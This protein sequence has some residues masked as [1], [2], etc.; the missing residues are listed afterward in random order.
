MFKKCLK[1]NPTFISSQHHLGIMYHRTKQF[2]NALQCY[3]QVL[4]KV[5]TDK[6]G[7]IVYLARGQVY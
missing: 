1:H 5:K 2:Q 7:K 3:S 4:E 6:K